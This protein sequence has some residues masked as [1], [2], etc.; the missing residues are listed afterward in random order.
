MTDRGRGWPKSVS[1]STDFGFSLSGKLLG[2]KIAV[3]RK[4]GKGVSKEVLQREAEKG[5]HP[6]IPKW[7]FGDPKT[8]EVTW[9]VG[10]QFWQNC[11]SLF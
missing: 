6:H 2:N 7:G 8:S 11:V 3:M 4:A 10:R 5:F 9:L 1:E